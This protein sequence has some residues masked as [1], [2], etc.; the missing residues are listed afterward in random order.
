MDCS[1]API[2]HFFSVALDGAT[3]ERQI[4][5]RVFFVNFV[6]VWG[7]IASSI[8]NRFERCFRNL[9]QDK[10]YFELEHARATRLEYSEQPYSQVALSA[11]LDLRS[12]DACLVPK[13]FN[14]VVLVYYI[15]HCSR[16]KYAYYVVC[17]YSR[18]CNETVVSENFDGKFINTMENWNLVVK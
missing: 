2:F 8:M 4:Y 11:Q 15:W 6:P 18:Y 5:I 9:S 16:L 13:K 3:T 12:Q 17:L 7:T 14:V 10:M 1:C